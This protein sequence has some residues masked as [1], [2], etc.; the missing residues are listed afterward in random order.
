MVATTASGLAELVIEH[1]GYPAQPANPASL[2][3]AI[4]K[5]LATIPADRARL[6]AAGRHLAAVRYD[7]T[8]TVGIFLRGIAPRALRNDETPGTTGAGRAALNESVSAA[9]VSPRNR[10]PRVS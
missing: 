6:R 9:D 8:R 7:Y 2:A 4:A 3:T 10:W 5:T 1:T